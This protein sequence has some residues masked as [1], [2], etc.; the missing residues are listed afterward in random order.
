MIQDT[1]YNL[2]VQLHRVDEK[3]AR[4]TDNANILKS[5]VDLKDE[6]DVTKQCLRICEDARSY[7]ES[8]TSFV[9]NPAI[10]FSDRGSRPYCL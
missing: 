4:F 5:T 2:E 9:L 3:M 8:L 1:A 6:R 10:C 7:L